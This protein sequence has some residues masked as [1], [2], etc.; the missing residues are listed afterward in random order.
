MTNTNPILGYV[1]LAKRKAGYGFDYQAVGDVWPN[2][3]DVE[4][5]RDDLVAEHGD[6]DVEYVVGE[7]RGA[8]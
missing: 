3:G 4:A 8:L 6:T 1:V 7:I 2:R 5:R